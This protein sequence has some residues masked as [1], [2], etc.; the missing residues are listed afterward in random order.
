MKYFRVELDEEQHKEVKTMAALSGKTMQQY[1]L[2]AI[3][4]KME[5]EKGL[6]MFRLNPQKRQE[7]QVK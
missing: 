3:K 7:R 6:Y 5:R 1:L 4:E 2:E